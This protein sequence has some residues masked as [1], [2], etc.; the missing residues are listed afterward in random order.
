MLERGI[1]AAGIH[2]DFMIG[3]ADVDV[4]GLDRVGN[5]TPIISGDAWQLA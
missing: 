2:V 4:D 1:N 3:G 5:A